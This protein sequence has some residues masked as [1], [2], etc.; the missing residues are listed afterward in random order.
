M[1]ICTSCGRSLQAGAKVC[2]GCGTKVI[3][4][5]ITQTSSSLNKSVAPPPIKAPKAPV[6]IKEQV[7]EEVKPSVQQSLPKNTGFPAAKF[8]L[9]I[10]VIATVYWFWSSKQASEQEAIEQARIAETQKIEAEKAIKEKE[11]L[12]AQAAAK[13]EKEKEALKA[14]AEEL[15][16]AKEAALE[17]KRKADEERKALEQAKLDNDRKVQEQAKAA[18]LEKARLI[19]E[20][21]FN[22]DRSRNSSAQ[23]QQQQP[24][25]PAPSSA[26]TQTAQPPVSDGEKHTAYF[27]GAFRMLITKR[28]YPTEDM[29]NQALEIWKNKKEILE[30]DGTTSKPPSADN[31]NT[32]IPH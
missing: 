4:N 13:A 16:L 10:V 1:I 32:I 8:I 21:Q 19:R 22:L 30:L 2:Q 7:K 14:Q 23:Q 25:N 31:S 5:P 26:N 11:A 18:E 28:S 20:R 15:K 24:I 27:R 29:K 12:K 3:E 6:P 17:A 9:V